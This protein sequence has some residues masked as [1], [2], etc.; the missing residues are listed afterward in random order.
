MQFRLALTAFFVAALALSTSTVARAE[1]YVVLNTV[2]LHFKNADERRAFTP[3]I[4]WEY[5]P[6]TKVGF[7]VGTLSDSFGFQASYGGINWATRKFNAGPAAF[8]F[9]VG[10]TLLHKQFHKNSDP[11]TKVVPFPAIEVSFSKRAV[12]N[13][14]GSPQIDFAGQRNNAVMFF[15]FKWNTR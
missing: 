13:V 10:A 3:G 8:R 1:N 14:S 4:G 5:S 9:I 15:Q 6:S 2:A 12:L 11:E 7:H